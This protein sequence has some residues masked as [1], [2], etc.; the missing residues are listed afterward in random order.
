MRPSSKMWRA[1]GLTVVLTLLGG[2]SQYV[3]RQEGITA[4]AGDAMAADRVTMMVDPWPP[5]SADKNIAFNG[6]R[7]QSAIARYR[8]NKVIP[9]TIDGTSGAYQAQQAPQASAAPAAAA[10]VG[11]TVTQ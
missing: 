1:L 10:P 8:T 3:A 2:C 4:N 11:P 7:M 5:A 9:P 6:E